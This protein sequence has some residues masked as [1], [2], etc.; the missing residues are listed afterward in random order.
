MKT[1]KNSQIFLEKSKRIPNNPEMILLN[2]ENNRKIP[3]KVEKM[4]EIFS[5]I[6][7]N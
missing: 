7:E 6:D 3:I 1:S 2:A 5:K 4:V